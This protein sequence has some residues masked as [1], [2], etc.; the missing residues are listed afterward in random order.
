MPS[1]GETGEELRFARSDG[2][3]ELRGDAALLDHPNALERAWAALADPNAGD[4]LVSAT[5]GWEFADLGGAHHAGGGSHG[6]LTAA[7][8][9]VP[10]LTVGFEA[11]VASITDVAPAILERFGVEPPSYARLAHAA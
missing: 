10:L 3:W 9:L 8:S 2:G 5:P 7:D 1:P 11:P 4:V 6:S